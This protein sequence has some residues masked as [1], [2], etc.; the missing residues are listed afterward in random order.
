[1]KRSD[2]DDFLACYH[3]ENRHEREETE[4]FK[5]FSYEDLVKRDKINLDIFWLKDDSLEDSA[6]LPDPGV[7]ALE[8]AED[9]EAALRPVLPNR[10]RPQ[11]VT[12]IDLKTSRSIRMLT[13]K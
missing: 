8:I 4:R 2:L 10:R 6:N 13:R 9:L 11:E 7:I 12:L 3:G 5:S 1:M